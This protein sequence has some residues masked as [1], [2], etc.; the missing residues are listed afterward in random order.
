M[1]LSER[2]REIRDAI[3]PALRQGV[4]KV[5]FQKADGSDRIMR[6]TLSREHLPPL[7]E[8]RDDKKRMPKRSPHTLVAWDVEA[9]G[10]RSF[11]LSSVVTW[12]PE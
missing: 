2:E 12:N 10:W 5:A 9:D 6:C 8:G 11:N 3:L 7:P 1:E 4:V